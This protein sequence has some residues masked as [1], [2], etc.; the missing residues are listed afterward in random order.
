[1]I[2]VVP[3]AGRGSRFTERGVETPKP[4]VSVAGRP[5]LAWAL[6]SLDGVAYSR[7]VF[8]ALAEHEAQYGISRI[9]HQITQ[10]KTEI[11][12][13]DDVT[14]GQLCTVLAAREWI[15]TDEDVLVTNSDTYVQS[16]LGRVIAER[17]PVCQGLIS[18][19]DMPGDRWSFARVDDHG[20]VVEV[21][22][23]VRIS[24]HASTGLYYF[25]HGRTFVS[26]A[27]EM[28]RNEEKTRGEYYVI[29]V[30]Q[31]YIERGWQVG[32]AEVDAMWDMGTPEA[33]AAFERHL[34]SSELRDM[35]T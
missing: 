19:S 30:Y 10:T 25:S 16:N 23:K 11:V 29:P 20:H 3:M 21:A 7:I 35:K 18:V 6:K 26:V 12:L 28:I 22:E 32:I 15:D 8:V 1:M 2:V 24:N 34:A 31:K 33:L 4:L 14:E 17:N 5:M 13:L 27:D 9:L